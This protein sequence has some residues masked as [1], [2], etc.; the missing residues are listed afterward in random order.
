MKKTK[1]IVIDGA[2]NSGK[3]TQTQLLRE[4]HAP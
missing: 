4:R 3:A 2:D 1:L